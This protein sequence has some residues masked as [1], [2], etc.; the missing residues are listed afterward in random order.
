MKNARPLAPHAHHAAALDLNCDLGESEPPA[1]TAALMACI[2]SANIACGGHAGDDAS[3]RHAIGLALT[4]GVRIGAHPG[5]PGLFGRAEK[6]LAAEEFTALLEGQLRRLRTHLHDVGAPLHHIKLHG[7]LYHLTEREAVLRKAYV[8]FV[9]REAPHA[10]IFALA[11]GKTVH[12]ARAAGLTAWDEAFGDRGYRHDGSLVPR[13]EPGALLS[14]PA[15]VAA[16]V[17]QIA[18]GHITPVVG[19]PPLLLQ[20][21]TVCIHGDSP[22]SPALLHAAANA[23]KMLDTPA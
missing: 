23:L 8:S 2:T 9:Q 17:R 21:Q 7:A 5:L 12:A 16:Q 3:M 18:A 14:D 20:A 15:S 13:G 4:H 11:G 19:G 6:M 1:H 10:L 22:D